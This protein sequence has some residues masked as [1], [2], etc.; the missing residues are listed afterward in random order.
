M[1]KKLILGAL[2]GIF[3]L[4]LANLNMNAQALDCAEAENCPSY[5]GDPD[6][7]YGN[8]E[9]S[10]WAG[11]PEYGDA[12]DGIVT[13]SDN[14]AVEEVDIEEEIEEEP[15]MWPVYLSFGAIGVTFLLVLTINLSARKYNKK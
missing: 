11:S 3:S 5:Y 1:Y 15:A 6:G 2:A 9:G 10:V 4:G 14:I 7:Y 13:T 8:A 12:E